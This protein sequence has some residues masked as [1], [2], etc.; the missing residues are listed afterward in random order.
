M[1]TIPRAYNIK[2]L[3]ILK[4]KLADKTVARPPELIALYQ[5]TV[6]KIEAELAQ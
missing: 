2:F 4:A 1:T 5:R 3:A 6:A